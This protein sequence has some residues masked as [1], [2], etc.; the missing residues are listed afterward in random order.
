MSDSMGLRQPADDELQTADLVAPEDPWGERTHNGVVT[1]SEDGGGFTVDLLTDPPA[2][3]V[4][5]R[6][7]APPLAA[8][9]KHLSGAAWSA[10]AE[11]RSIPPPAAARPALDEVFHARATLVPSLPDLDDAIG[12]GD[13]VEAPVI[14][15]RQP[16]ARPRLD[17]GGYTIVRGR[18][19]GSSMD[20]LGDRGA[21]VATTEQ[22]T[23][24]AEAP[25]GAVEDA[26]QAEAEPSIQSAVADDVPAAAAAIDAERAVEAFIRAAIDAR[27]KRP[28][29]DEAWSLVYLSLALAACVAAYV[30]TIFPA[31]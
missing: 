27:A 7:S 21:P 11:V 12:L 4:P 25:G 23:A 10:I 16:P 20:A 2:P 1:A 28:P 22:G 24:R 9:E 13:L 17:A 30:W 18:D 14:I 15:E 29:Q 26:T 3:S 6:W 8:V 19:A 31:S 5:L